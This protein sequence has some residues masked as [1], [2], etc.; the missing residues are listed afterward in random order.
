MSTSGRSSEV[1]RDLSANLDRL[2]HDALVHL[3]DPTYLQTHPL[4]HLVATRGS[5]GERQLG[6]ALRRCLLEAVEALR[7][8]EAAEDSARRGYD[9][10]RLRYVEALE[11]PEVERQVGLSRR[12]C[13]R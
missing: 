8:G 3:H 11:I 9:V 2:V 5:R 4:A 10:L 12:Q 13:Q 7:P 6:E 1:P